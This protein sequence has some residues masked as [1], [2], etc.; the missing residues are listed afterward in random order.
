MINLPWYI[1]TKYKQRKK[2]RGKK[3][4]KEENDTT[5]H[6]MHLHYVQWVTQFLIYVCS[7]L[8]WF[9]FCRFDA[10]KT[11]IFLYRIK[12]NIYSSY[13]RIF[14]F[15]HSLEKDDFFSFPFEGS[16]ND[17]LCRSTNCKLAHPVPPGD[18]L[19]L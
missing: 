17:G 3:D 9:Q 1:Y 11:I 16:S 4:K 7:F 5:F 6:F 13:H 18:I 8:V 2:E 12:R 10:G 14:F 15:L 19:G